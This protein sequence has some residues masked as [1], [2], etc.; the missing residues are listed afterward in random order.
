MASPTP[1]CLIV[2]SPLRMKLANTDAMISAAARRDPARC[3]A[4]PRRTACPAVLA[5]GVVA[6]ATWLTRNTS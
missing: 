2:G 6:A 4:R 5:R 3:D 1:N